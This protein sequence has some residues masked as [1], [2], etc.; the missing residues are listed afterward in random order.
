M[1]LLPTSPVV[2]DLDPA[3][4]RAVLYGE[5]GAGKS[6]LAAG[7]YPQTNL[8]IDVEGSTRFLPGE[9][10]VV[11]LKTYDEFAAVVNELVTTQHAYTTVTIDS[12]DNL[13]RMADSAAGQRHGKIAA[14]L[15]EYGKGTADRNGV[16]FRD[17]N[18][19]LATDL[20]VLAIAH[21]IKVPVIDEDTGKEQG[22]KY[23]PRIEEG[24]TGDKLRRPIIS[25]FDFVLAL[26]KSPDE[27]RALI[28]GNTAAYEVKRRVALPDVLPADAGQ[29]Y[30][31]VKAGIDNLNK[32]TVTV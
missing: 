23:F 21:A 17:L 5:P 2:N 31:A 24:L 1:S 10:L 3:R 4:L 22:D 27:S 6:T 20:G 11:R 7:W 15:V 29:L 12:L 13:V 32:E 8:L 14:G 16:L 18:K 30:T 25:L 9:H 19:L 28:T 26:R